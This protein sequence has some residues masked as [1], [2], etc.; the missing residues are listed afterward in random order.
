MA[1]QAYQNAPEQQQPHY[2]P[3]SG[4][5]NERHAAHGPIK[6]QPPG[7]QQQP[8]IQRVVVIIVHYL[9]IKEEQEVENESEWKEGEAE[10]H[11]KIMKTVMVFQNDYVE[12]LGLASCL[13]KLHK[14]QHEML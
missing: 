7:T 14:R 2:P 9:P 8:G 13:F 3:I 1:Y 5:L 10:E 4:R 11:W 6:T 12:Q